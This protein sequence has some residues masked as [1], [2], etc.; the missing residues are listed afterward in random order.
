MPR[1]ITATRKNESYCINDDNNK[2][3]CILGDPNL[4]KWDF[5]S[6]CLEANPNKANKKKPEPPDLLD[7]RN[8]YK[9][10]HGQKFYDDLEDPTTNPP[11]PHEPPPAEATGEATHASPPPPAPPRPE[12]ERPSVIITPN[13][14][15]DGL[16][17][18]IQGLISGDCPPDFTSLDI[19]TE[20]L[21]SF[22]NRENQ[23][24]KLLAQVLACIQEQFFPQ[25]EGKRSNKKWRDYIIKT[26]R[27][28]YNY[29]L[30]LIRAWNTPILQEFWEELGMH[31]LQMLL[32]YKDKITP[33]L[34]IKIISMSTV[35]AKKF[36]FPRSTKSKEPSKVDKLI[37]SIRAIKPSELAPQ[38]KNKLKLVLQ[39]TLRT[40]K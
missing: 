25:P 17:Q 6:S 26:V 37:T 9:T 30:K 8:T 19:A 32:R 13:D 23:N 3:L 21:K 20:T 39:E 27:Y 29:T 1:T 40:L 10:K 16:T 31:K 28:D 14:G 2:Q 34:I 35:E 18:L 36:L 4:C 12:Q 38:T 15:N 11:Q 5:Y 24:S 22:L 33:E 7:A